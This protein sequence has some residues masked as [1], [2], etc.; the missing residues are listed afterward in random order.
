MKL[1]IG[2]VNR[3]TTRGKV[4]RFFRTI[5]TAMVDYNIKSE[6]KLKIWVEEYIDFYNN[7]RCHHAL[8]FLRPADI[9]E[10]RAQQ[11]LEARLAVRNSSPRLRG[12]QLQEGDTILHN[13]MADPSLKRYVRL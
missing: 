10:G 7:T 11:I 1:S 12:E 5:K 3:P 2:K 9:Y 8:S 13:Q 4:E 6:K